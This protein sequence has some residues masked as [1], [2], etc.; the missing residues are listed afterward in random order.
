MS[1]FLVCVAWPYANGPIHVG[2]VAG[3]Y[4]PPDIFARYQ[5]L[6]G[7]DVLM[8]SGS[9][10]HGT[11]ITVTA[12]E[13]GT[14]PQ[15]IAD[16]YHQINS[17]A[18]EDLGISFSLF[19]QTSDPN[20]K[21]VAQEIFLKLLEND[22]VYKQTMN[23]PYCP[24]CK[25]Y[26]P[27]RYIEGEC[28]H[29]H[30]LNARGDQCD[31]CGKTLDAAELINSSCKIC[32]AEPYLRETEHFFLKLSAFQD[33]L[34]DYVSDKKHWKANVRTFTRNWLEA[35]LKDRPITRD[36]EWGIEIP[37]D[38]YENKRI[39]VWFEAV[40]GYLSTSKE[41]ARQQGEPD[42]WKEYWEDPATRHYY[43]LGKDNIPF[44]T[45]IWPSILMGIGGLNL[46]YDVPA[47]EYLRLKGEKFSK[48]KGV[49]VDIPSF[50]TAFDPD[51]LRYYLSINM[52]ENRDSDFSWPD[53]GR[54]INTELVGNLGNFVHRVLSFTFKNYKVCPEPLTDSDEMDNKV[55]E[56]IEAAFKDI[57]DSLE[58]CQFKNG[59]KALMA[60][61][62]FGNKYFDEAAPWALIKKDK[63]A[64]GHK[65]YYCLKLV[66]ALNVMMI[67]F[68]PFSAEKLWLMTGSE[69]SISELKWEDALIPIP[70]G[71][72]LQKPD[73]LYKKLDLKEFE[74][75][76]EVEEQKVE[77]VK[78]EK[79]KEKMKEDQV[80]EK[81]AAE[82]EYV[83]FDDFQK[84]DLSV[85]KILEVKDHP[86][87]DKLYVMKVDFGDEQTQIVAGLKKYYEKADMEGKLIVVVRNL[88][89]VK[90]RGE[91]SNGMLLAAEDSTGAV[92]MI[93]PE[94]EV[95]LGAKVR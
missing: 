52:P 10:Q 49:S 55:D 7:N 20:H 27:D 67:P 76:G 21:K 68:M 85:G 59:M 61:A 84:M 8:V 82:M 89:P 42:K 88:E 38:G 83:K 90:L 93:T 95:K 32:G 11:P 1:K 50:L 69:S 63:E 65:L 3:C 12:L 92:V 22:Y 86:N 4:L 36:M 31:E 41:W 46:P 30:A 94:K 29:C 91:E 28:P 60:L 45:I 39:Y 53:F 14:T 62:Q 58:N 33:K 54:R 75:G 78:V 2:H 57:S 51:V 64:C 56:Q 23:S 13:E 79:K 6:K 47:N 25:L 15:A 66:K 9:D 48:S 71:Q 19:F 72:Q 87:A 73:P 16:K 43:F 37:L 26:L 34:K 80:V 5:R 44:H 17:K 24:S 74:E 77:A 81:E 18:L 35:G 70:A 40:I